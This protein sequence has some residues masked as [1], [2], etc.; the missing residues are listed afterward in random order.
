[1]SRVAEES[2]VEPAPFAGNSV[3]LSTYAT[4]DKSLGVLSRRVPA[5]RIQANALDRFM[6]HMLEQLPPISVYSGD[7]ARGVF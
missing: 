2:V 7:V 6:V 4:I 3:A 5:E 1:M